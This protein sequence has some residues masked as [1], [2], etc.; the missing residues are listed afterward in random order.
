MELLFEQYPNS[1]EH[2]ANYSTNLYTAV[3]TLALI[4]NQSWNILNSYYLK[5]VS[6][7]CY[8]SYDCQDEKRPIALFLLIAYRT[9][10]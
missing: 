5:V 1:E 8:I 3:F 2:S 7:F 4:K 6:L 10:S 9:N